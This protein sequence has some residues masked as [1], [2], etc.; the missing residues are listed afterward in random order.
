MSD[1]PNYALVIEILS[2]RRWSSWRP[3]VR[4][5][6]SASRF[7]KAFPTLVWRK[8]KALALPY[9]DWLIAAIVSKLPFPILSLSCIGLRKAAF[10]YD[11]RRALSGT[12]NSVVMP[13][14]DPAIQRRIRNPGWPHQVRP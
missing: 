4:L 14:F 1:P 11:K 3:W 9:G 2:G 7:G 5:G 10:D 12:A 8:A 13:G 6:A